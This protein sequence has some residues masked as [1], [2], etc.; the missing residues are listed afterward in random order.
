MNYEFDFDKVFQSRATQREIFH[1]ISQLVQVLFGAV[2]FYSGDVFFSL[3]FTGI[4]S[5]LPFLP[6]VC[7]AVFP[8][9]YGSLNC[10]Y[11]CNIRMFQSALDGYNVSIFAYGQTGSGKTFTMEGP[12]PEE[13]RAD[14]ELAGMIQLAVEQ[15]FQSVREL[16]QRGWTVSFIVLWLVV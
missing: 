5:R 3:F 14:P 6:T 9:G 7:S 4:V 8:T 10:G 16:K 2:P 15:V 11:I 13:I 12:G 1:E